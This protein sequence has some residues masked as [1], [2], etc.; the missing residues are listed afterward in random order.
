M[1]R[2]GMQLEELPEVMNIV[3]RLLDPEVAMT[4][5]GHI[6]HAQFALKRMV[7]PASLARPVLLHAIA[8]VLCDNLCLVAQP[9][10]DGSERWLFAL[11]PR[12]GSRNM[13]PPLILSAVPP[14][15]TCTRRAR[16]GARAAAR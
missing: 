12:V 11:R 7:E 3:H 1:T 5:A 2:T 13:L 14:P 15:S 6:L 4:E 16:P 9:D 10:A 8:S